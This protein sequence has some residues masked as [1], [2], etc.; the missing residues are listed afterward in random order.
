MVRYDSFSVLVAPS[1]GGA[2]ARHVDY[3]L[4]LNAFRVVELFAVDAALALRDERVD[5]FLTVDAF[6]G[7]R[8]PCAFAKPK[9]KH[10][11]RKQMNILIL[12]LK[13]M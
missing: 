5:R 8:E 3:A 13:F 10:H 12:F 1:I 11:I 4:V 2:G 9:K 6:V 7:F